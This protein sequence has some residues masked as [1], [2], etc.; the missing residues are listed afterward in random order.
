[1]SQKESEWNLQNWWTEQYWIVDKD[2]K[3]LY[4]MW[5]ASYSQEK[6]CED[7]SINKVNLA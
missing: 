6:L 4:I 2:D 7:Y 1:M 3:T 5:G